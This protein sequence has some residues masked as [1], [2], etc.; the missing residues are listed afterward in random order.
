MRLSKIAAM[1]VFTGLVQ[2]TAAAPPPAFE[3]AYEVAASELTL[4]TSEYGSVILRACD[5]C[6]RITLRVD[7]ETRY[8][9]GKNTLPLQEFRAL[10][11]E[12]PGAD[13]VA[14]TV[15]YRVQDGRVAR[16]IV[17]PPRS[18]DRDDRYT[19]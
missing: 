16:I 1:L 2:T 19:E 14:A 12:M 13:D 17:M 8:I 6:D 5:D 3:E 18:D 15:I 4:P 10:V 9:Y 11:A 7:G